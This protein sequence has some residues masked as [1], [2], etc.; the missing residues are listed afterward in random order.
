MNEEKKLGPRMRR[1]AEAGK[2]QSGEDGSGENA[3]VRNILAWVRD[4]AIAVVVA[5]VVIQFITP[6]VVDGSSME[7]NLH[8]GDYLIMSKQSYGLFGGEPEYGDVVVVKTHLKDEKNHDKLIIKRV[9]GLPGD[10]I[11]IE[12]GDVYVNG[13]VQ[14][15]SYTKDQV[16]NGI[17]EGLVV[18]ENSI[19]CLGDNRL[20]SKDSRSSEVGC[21]SEDDI[22]GKVVL[23]L[24]PL[25]KIGTIFNPYDEKE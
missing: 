12:N 8:H 19:F 4:I 5:L 18:P 25:D 20:N 23:R 22:V 15:D 3:R 14:D 7:P 6:T 11:T 2:K 1:R 10:E 21:I 9:I 16:T 24:L 17:I 13:E